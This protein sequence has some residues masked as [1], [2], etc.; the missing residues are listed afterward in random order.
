MF[1]GRSNDYN[2]LKGT[3]VVVRTQEETWT[4]WGEAA[5]PRDL[6]PAANWAAG[7]P[8][9]WRLRHLL[10]AGLRITFFAFAPPS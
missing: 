1:A 5:S 8:S 3:G 7:A 2:G 9:T 4:Q 6:E 10:G